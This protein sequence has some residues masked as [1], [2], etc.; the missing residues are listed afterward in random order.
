MLRILRIMQHIDHTRAAYTFRVVHTGIR[1]VEVLA[2]LL[3]T[4]F[5]K[6]LHVVLASKVQ[7][8][9]GTRLNTRRLQPFAHSVA[10]KRA[11]E[12]AMRLRIHLRNI[13]WTPRD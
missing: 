11:L 8:A 3:R 13:E 7:A 4:L 10:A 1:E 5:R 6:V 9:R 12:D 2:Q